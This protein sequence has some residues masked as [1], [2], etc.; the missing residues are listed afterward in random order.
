MKF[1]T[2]GAV[3]WAERNR[4][5]KSFQM[6]SHISTRILWHGYWKQRKNVWKHKLSSNFQ[7]HQK[8]FHVSTLYNY[9][10]REIIKFWMSHLSHVT[11]DDKWRKNGINDSA[12]LVLA[13]KPKC[14]SRQTN[15]VIFNI[16]FLYSFPST[17]NIM[18][19]GYCFHLP[20]IRKW[21]KAAGIRKTKDQK[22]KKMN[23]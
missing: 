12:W 6:R 21:I 5:K 15:K 18:I 9:V 3:W 16:F 4:K 8:C 14:C 13:F 17:I 7:S 23:K 11:M 22:N 1:M 19:I 2:R 10:Q 20:Q